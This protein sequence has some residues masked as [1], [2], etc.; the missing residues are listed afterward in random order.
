MALGFGVEGE[1]RNWS[2]SLAPHP[3]PLFHRR[4]E[5]NACREPMSLRD[6]PGKRWEGKVIGIRNGWSPVRVYSMAK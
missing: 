2:D 6:N 3:Q 5:M 1:S 4:E